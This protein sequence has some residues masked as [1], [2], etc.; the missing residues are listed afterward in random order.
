M[1]AQLTCNCIRRFPGRREGCSRC[2][3]DVQAM[4]TASRLHVVLPFLLIEFTLLF[5]GGVLVLLILRD[6]VIHVAFRFGKLH[7]VHSLTCVPME[8]CLTTEHRREVF[9]HTLEHLL[10]GR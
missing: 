9:S 4:A 8:E 6:Q 7:L 1:S 10:D 3:D 2:M 5:S